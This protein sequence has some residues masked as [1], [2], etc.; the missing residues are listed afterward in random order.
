MAI[1]RVPSRLNMFGLSQT[2]HIH[3]LRRHVHC[4]NHSRIVMSWGWLC[5]LPAF[6]RV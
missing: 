2:M 6:T 1:Y 4:I 3:V 5:W